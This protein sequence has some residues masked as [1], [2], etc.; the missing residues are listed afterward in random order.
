MKQKQTYFLR[1]SF[2]LVFFVM[3]GYIVKFYPENLTAIDSSIQTAIRGNLSNG[4]TTFFKIIT[5]FGNELIIFL[6]VLI[7]AGLFYY[8]KVWKSESFFLIGNLCLMGIF[9]TGFKYL[10][11]RPRPSLDYLIAKPLG[12]SFPSWHAASTFIVFICLIII[13]QERMKNLALRR[14]FQ[15]CLVILII[16]VGLSRIFLGVH[17]PSDIIGGWLLAYA[18]V[19]VTYPFYNQKRFEWRFHSKQK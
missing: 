5:I 12:P 19:N 11:N 10:Y 3:L 7:I 16:C 17:Y 15:A 6:Y 1:A 8:I 13:L 4:I 2:A 9:S 14:L 18:L